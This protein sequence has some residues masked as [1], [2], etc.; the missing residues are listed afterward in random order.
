[1]TLQQKIQAQITSHGTHATGLNLLSECNISAVHIKICAS[2]DNSFTRA[3]INSL[4]SEYLNT[5]LAVESTI[6]PPAPLQ[7]GNKKTRNPSDRPDA[8]ALILAAVLRRKELYGKMRE[9]HAQ[10]K[11]MVRNADKFSNLDR[12]AV[13]Q[14]SKRGWKEIDVLWQYAKYYDQ[15]RKIKP[16]PPPVVKI[17]IADTANELQLLKRLRTLRTYLSPSYIQRINSPEKS[18]AHK[19]ELSAIETKLKDLE[20][21]AV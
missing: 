11:M 17:E 2:A 10:L 14:E 1:M 7:F 16:P 5:Q 4:I 3:K 8:P 19:S 20:L 12:A 21:D 15:H 13:V 6:I 18:A 9:L